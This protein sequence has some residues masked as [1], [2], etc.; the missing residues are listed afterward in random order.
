MWDTPSL[1]N[2]VNGKKGVEKTKGPDYLH[3]LCPLGPP[4][5]HDRPLGAVDPGHDARGDWVFV[6][7]PMSDDL[8]DEWMLRDMFF[9]GLPILGVKYWF[10]EA[11]MSIRV[12]ERRGRY[13]IRKCRTY[14]WGDLSDRTT[15]RTTS[16]QHTTSF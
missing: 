16:L 14:V 4:V 15:V 2:V 5:D 6:P 8:A 7:D 11:L 9:P 10:D 12:R 13:R 1:S 3:F